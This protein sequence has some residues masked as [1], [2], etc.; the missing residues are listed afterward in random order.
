MNNPFANAQINNP[1]TS[2]NTAT[3]STAANSQNFDP[4]EF[5]WNL[6]TVDYNHIDEK[7]KDFAFV[8]Q[9]GNALDKSLEKLGKRVASASSSNEVYKNLSSIAYQNQTGIMNELSTMPKGSSNVKYALCEIVQDA[10][11]NYSLK[12][13]NMAI[14][15]LRKSDVKQVI[16]PTT[17]IQNGYASPCPFKIN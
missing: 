16:N 12:P 10:Q 1:F 14:Q 2:N 15:I 7:T 13:T 17:A 9:S 11:G 8:T 4:S 5:W 6:G 3:A